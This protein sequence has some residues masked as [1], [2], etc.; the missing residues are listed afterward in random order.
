M[1]GKH[2]G[3]GGRFISGIRKPLGMRRRSSAVVSVTVLLLATGG[4]AAYADNL[5]SDGDGVTPLVNRDL[6]LGDICVDQTTTRTV[7]IGIN[8]NGAAGSTN[9]FKNSSTVTVS[10]LNAVGAGLTANVGSPNTISVPATWGAQA[11]NAVTGEVAATISLHPTGLG[12]FSGSVEFRGAGTNSGN[13]AINRDDTMTVTANVINCAPADTTAPTIG[14]DVSGTLGTDISLSTP[15]V[16]GWYRSDVGVDWTVTDNESAVSSSSGCDDESI[17]T[18]G[19]YNRTCSATS[20]GGTSSR[21]VT[22]KRDATAPSATPASVTATTGIWTQGPVSETFS[23]ADVTSGLA[24]NPDLDPDDKATLTVSDESVDDVTPTS[25]SITVFDEAGNSVTRSVAAFID[26][27]KPTNVQFVGGPAADGVYFPNNVPASPTCT[28][29]DPLSGLDSCVVSGYSTAEGT[30]TMTATATDK[31]GNTETATV[32]Y[33]VRVLSL[34][35]FF[36]PVD[37]GVNA[38][39]AAK[40]GSTVPLKFRVFDEGVEQTATSI[41]KSF[42]VGEIACGTLGTVADDI[43]QYTSGSTSLR[44]DS[45]GQQFIQNWQTPAKKA[46]ACYKVTMTTIDDSA[47]SAYFKLR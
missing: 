18:D 1:A 4:A 2:R 27:T 16:R 42:K 40:S 19:T 30:H 17:T 29:D 38:L 39:N 15:D 7:L 41:V 32:S 22:V 35:G 9:V 5:V 45:T 26:K 14:V 37:M 11:N 13:N 25:A 28:A 33:R 21:S 12:S 20:A 10:V 8:R 31:A 43:E 24:T 36:Q 46:G 6:A 44:Y 3:S 23:F 34:N 47:I